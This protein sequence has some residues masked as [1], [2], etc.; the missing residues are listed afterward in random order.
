MKTRDFL[1]ELGVEELPAN[2]IDLSLQDFSQSFKKILIK[3]KIQHNQIE[4]YSTPRRLAILC[5]QVQEKL[6]G[7]RIEKMGPPIEKC[8]EGEKL[9]SMGVGYFKSLDRDLM[10]YNDIPKIKDTAEGK[11]EGI[12]ILDKNNK[13]FL[14]SIRIQASRES[15]KILQNSLEELI[16]NIKFKKTMRWHLGEHSF[17]RP[18]KWIVCLW[19]EEIIDF[20]IYGIHSSNKTLSHP[21][22]HNNQF[23]TLNRASDYVQTLHS[24]GVIVSKTKR[25]DMIKNQIEKH[26]LK[27]GVEYQIVEEKK[28][29]QEVSHLLEYPQV[30]LE[31]FDKK[32][33]S[34]PKEVAI[35]EMVEHQ[36]YFPITKNGNLTEAFFIISNNGDNENIRQGNLK[37]LTSR[38]SDGSFLYDEDIKTGIENMGKG[39]EKTLFQKDLGNYTQR[40]ERLRQVAHLLLPL[41]DGNELKD[42]VL[43]VIQLM[44]NDL[45]SSMVYEFPHLQGVMGEYYAKAA[46]FD[47]DVCLAIKEHYYPLY[48]GA[49]LPSQLLGGVVALIDK[50]ENIFSC[51]SVGLIPTGSNDPYALRRQGLS[52]I[53]IL[54]EY[55]INLNLLEVID[56][57]LPLYQ[58]FIKEK[59]DLS[60]SEIK[61][62]VK[63]FFVTRALGHYSQFNYPPDWIK[64]TMANHQLKINNIHSIL[65]FIKSHHEDKDFILVL[66][67]IKRINHVVENQ[68]ASDFNS[69]LLQINEEK[70][71][72]QVLD[73]KT[74]LLFSLVENKKY[75]EFVKEVRKIVPFFDSFFDK[76][77]V[78]VQDKRL[79]NN[80]KAL[81]KRITKPF[82][83][84]I[85]FNLLGI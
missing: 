56:E 67:L 55:K 51:F 71:L 52:I 42:Q 63:K 30:I 24:H 10:S 54:C 78:N 8:F 19:G 2:E 43:Q 1:I 33:L 65:D 25:I 18:L 34:Y 45:C 17:C 3:N 47:L 37:V 20:E 7:S 53:R 77:M 81:L 72:S 70:K 48:S 16:R 6:T 62:K 31:H 5:L 23:I 82:D 58:P 85:D 66:N 4:T 41:F 61:E 57:L 68:L 49:E 21:Y 28:L 46:Q 69:N 11:K 76:V 84:F 14:F 22:T 9:N 40:I 59:N 80:R 26:L 32:F 50:I 29:L 74:N 27:M 35:S 38:L 79:C 15:S 36:K 13:E 73:K 12:Y 64:A 39:L 75:E 60:F 44:K 83:L